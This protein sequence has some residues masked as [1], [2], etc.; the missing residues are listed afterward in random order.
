MKTVILVASISVVSCGSPLAPDDSMGGASGGARSPTGGANMGGTPSDT[1][2]SSAGG[3]VDSEKIGVGSEFVLQCENFRPAE[4]KRCTVRTVTCEFRAS[5]RVAVNVAT[6]CGLL[7]AV[8]V[9]EL[10]AHT[11]ARGSTSVR[12]SCSM[13]SS[14]RNEAPCTVVVEEL[15]GIGTGGEASAPGSRV[16][17]TVECP[18]G[19]VQDG[20]D[21]VG[22]VR[23]RFSP[24]SFRVTVADCE[25]E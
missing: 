18:D 19:L 11:S 12:S 20:G 16:T 23:K 10:G 7:Q 24:S 1:G 3:S 25:A 14:F 17:M 15:V 22:L 4:D 21:D 6:E 9:A 8:T 13:S 2:G 5:D